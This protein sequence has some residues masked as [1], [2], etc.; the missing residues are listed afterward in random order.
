M[1]LIKMVSNSSVLRKPL[2]L[3]FQL[4]INL[5]CIHISELTYFHYCNYNKY[6]LMLC[7]ETHYPMHL[8]TLHMLCCIQ[9]ILVVS[10]LR[11]SAIGVDSCSPSNDARS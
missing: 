9:C 6:A 1:F 4:F 11:L 3:V 10:C 5:S 8:E 2:N 7:R